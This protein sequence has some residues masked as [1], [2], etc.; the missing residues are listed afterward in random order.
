MLGKFNLLCP[1][2]TPCALRLHFASAQPIPRSQLDQKTSLPHILSNIEQAICD[3]AQLYREQHKPLW[4]NTRPH[5]HF[6]KVPR[7]RELLPAVIE[8]S[9]ARSAEPS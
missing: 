5:P 1:A 6:P 4:A 7:V 9:L 8:N 3:S 2:L